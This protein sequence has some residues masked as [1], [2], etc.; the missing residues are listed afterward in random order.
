ME[1]AFV[2][3]MLLADISPELWLLGE[4]LFVGRVKSRFD[5][6]RSQELR[7]D[8]MVASTCVP[9]RARRGVL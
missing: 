7:A 9:L 4:K 5:V 3:P 6:P 1:I 8:L 2:F